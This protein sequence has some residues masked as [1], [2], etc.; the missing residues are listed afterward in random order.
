MADPAI[1]ETLTLA[2]TDDPLMSWLFEDATRRPAQLRHWWAWIIDHRHSHV[3]VRATDDDRSAAIWHGPDPGDGVQAASFT[4]MLAG[5]IGTDVVARKLPALG[6]IPAAHPI[7]RHWY[8]AAIGTRPQF[9][10]RGSG[11]RVL[12]P[13]LDRCDAE[14]VPAYLES[15]NTRNLPF[16]ERFGFVPTGIIQVPGGPALTSMWREPRVPAT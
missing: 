12:Q 3:E 9:Q 11:P 10:G 6:V 7:E 5:L 8:L 2:F 15:S 16:Y 13:V 14:G 4:E 1:V